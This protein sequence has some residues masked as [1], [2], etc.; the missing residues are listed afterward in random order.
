M[1]RWKI[2]GAAAVAAALM[3]SG[4]RTGD[5][6]GDDEQPTPDAADDVRDDDG[7][8]DDSQDRD[9]DSDT[10]T[11]GMPATAGDDPDDSGRD[12]GGVP[13]IGGIGEDDPEDAGDP[14]A[15]A[16]LAEAAAAS[17]GLSVRGVATSAFSDESGE[18]DRY[19]TSLFEFD[20]RGALAETAETGADAPPD[21]IGGELRY[22]GGVLYVRVSAASAAEMGFDV[23]GLDGEWAWLTVPAEVLEDVE[24]NYALALL[25]RRL[26]VDETGDITCDPMATTVALIESASGATIVGE[27]E[28]GGVSATKVSFAVSLLDVMGGDMEGIESMDDLDGLR[29]L[30]LDVEGPGLSDPEGPILT[31]FGGMGAAGMGAQQ[32][33]DDDGAGMDDAL[34]GFLLMM[35]GQLLES[36]LEAEIWIDEDKLIRRFSLDFA[37]M[38]DAFAG[39]E[40]MMGPSDTQM[41]G[42][43]HSAVVTVDFQDFDPDIIVDAPPSGSVVGELSASGLGLSAGGP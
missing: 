29:G 43:T 37:A 10:D 13:D 11:D 3:M 28:V 5:T 42:E 23:E 32:T 15:V 24:R 31:D 18:D 8:D 4:C 34:A 9:P 1:R 33:P 20:A 30:D 17:A 19:L 7:Q 16:L 38:F 26:P 39:L 22:A 35:L 25:C 6:S 27:E 41:S 12:D 21:R 14:E 36:G 2:V 40:E